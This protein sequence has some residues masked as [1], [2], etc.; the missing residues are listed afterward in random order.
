MRGIS[1]S[2][3]RTSGSCWTIRSR[4]TNGSDAR[5]TTSM[6]GSAL[7]ASDNIFRT[8]AESSTMRMRVLRGGN[9][10]VTS[11]LR[12]GGR[13]DGDE[14]DL[15]A[16]GQIVDGE[17]QAGPRFGGHRGPNAR[18]D[19]RLAEREGLLVERPRQPRTANHVGQFA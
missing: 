14:P 18:C 1:M 6:S 17:Q 15:D 7:S 9:D 10:M 8:I 11:R 4:A 2:S 13:R 3:V 5:P 19:D 16:A 12:H